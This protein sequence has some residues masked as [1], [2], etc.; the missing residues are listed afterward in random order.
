MALALY[1]LIRELA[2]PAYRSIP[3]IA[4]TAYAAVRERKKALEAGFRC[5][6]SILTNWRSVSTAITH[7]GRTERA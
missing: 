5:H 2:A 7:A 3:A 1:V 6:R 4:I